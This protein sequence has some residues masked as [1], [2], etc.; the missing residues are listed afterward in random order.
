MTELQEIEVYRMVSPTKG[1]DSEWIKKTFKE[2]EIFDFNKSYSYTFYTSKI[3]SW[4]NNN[5]RY[6]STN[7]LVPV[8]KYKRTE[9]FGLG[10]ANYAIYYFDNND[11]NDENEIGIKTD[12]DGKLCFVET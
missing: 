4:S 8:G 1:P 10:D 2:N 11:E 6:F 7:I 12:Y 9:S 5:E 3:G